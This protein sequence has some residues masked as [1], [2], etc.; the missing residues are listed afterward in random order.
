M[1]NVGQAHGMTMEAQFEVY[2]DQDSRQLLGTVVVCELNEFSTTL[3]TM[4]SKFVLEGDGVALQT[5]AGIDVRIHVAD[6]GLEALV[7][8]LD[9][10]QRMIRLVDRDHEAEFGMA[11]ENGKVVFNIFDSDVTKYGLTRMPFTLEPTLDV[12]SPVI[13]AAVHF[14]WHRR[15]TP[16]RTSGAASGLAKFVQVELTEL[17]EDGTYY[18]NL[19]PVY[20]P[21][22]W[23][24]GKD[25]DL[26]IK[27]E[28]TIYGWNIINNCSQPLYLALFY[29]DNSDW[30]ISK[31]N[32]HWWL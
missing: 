16:P 11:L 13:R 23:K 26:Q 32:H 24:R 20:R 29:F 22:D 18:D 17:E 2:Q 31:W 1:P 9:P 28:G 12:L 21:T 8:Q 19:E 15:R 7:R 5:C 25:F 27:D 4:G 10:L 14:Y 30:T 6:K 3:H